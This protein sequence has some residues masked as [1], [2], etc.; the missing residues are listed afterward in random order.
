MSR[1][2]LPLDLSSF[3]GRA[4]E[5]DQLAELVT[6]SRLITLT[7]GPGA[8]KTRLAL[9]LVRG[10]LPP[11]RRVAWTEL[12]PLGEP[13][14]VAP[15]IADALQ[16][17]EEV[18]AGDVEALA[19]LIGDGDLLLVLDNCEHLVDAVA[20]VA[21]VLLR[22]YTDLCIVATSREA[23][24]V[25]GERAW[26]VPPLALPGP[27]DAESLG[28]SEAVRLFLERARD[29][30]PGFELSEESAPAVAEICRRL[31]GIPLAIELAAARMRLMSPAEVLG[32]LDDVFHLLTDDRRTTSPRH[33][34][35]R[36]AIDWSHDLLR[37][38]AR[39]LLRRLAVFQGG[40]TLEAA[41]QVGPGDGIAPEEVLDGVG[42]LVD[43]SMLVVREGHGFTRYHLLEAVRQYA[44]EKL[45]ASGGDRDVRSVH[46]GYFLQLTEK[47]EPH[48][49]DRDRRVWVDRLQS[50]IDNLRAAL[51]WSR[52]EDPGLHVRLVGRLWWFW[53]STQHWTEGA[54]WID[55]ALALTPET[56]T[57]ADRA[58]LLFAAGALAALQVRTDAARAALEEAASIAARLGDA[59]LEAYAL[60]YLGMT[61][62]GEGDGEGMELCRRADAWFRAH[63]DLY[64]LR[65]ALLLQGSAALGRGALA[66]AERLN[67]EG[68]EVARR[69]GQPRELAVS[70]QNLSVVLIVQGRLD[71]AEALVLEALRTSREDL[72]YYFIA[73]GIAYLAEIEGHRGRSLEAARLFG[74][75]EALRERVSARP[76]PLDRRRMEALV[77]RLREQAGPVAFEGAW[78]TGRA[79]PP[80][81][82]L[83]ELAERGPGVEIGAG[84]RGEGR[85]RPGAGPEKGAPGGPEALVVEALGPF[86]AWVD[87]APVDEDRWPY[88][89]PRE[90]LAFLLLHPAGRTRDQVGEALWPGSAPSKLKNS[91]HVTLHHLR[92]A[93][94]R[95]GWIGVEG[96]RYRL[97]PE[98]TWRL[99][100]AEFETEGR[101]ALGD[102]SAPALRSA[103]ALYRGEL[104]EG[105]PA[106][107]WLEEHRERLQRLYVTLSLELA[108][109]LEETDPDGASAIYR[110]LAGREA[111]DE[112]IHRRLMTSLARA[113]DRVGALRH[114]D[115]L[116]GLLEHS[117]DATPEPATRELYD[118]LRAGERVG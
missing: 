42:H 76:F 114:Y 103:I 110:A 73:T 16:L 78:E 58:S 27:G 61:H 117:L 45:V 113:G 26:L 18:R 101:R 79:L 95:P 46:A 15:A 98:V 93:L 5:L 48:L 111:L 64:G 86:R 13:G 32:R 105:E 49:T 1:S 35:L 75:A 57:E 44:L 17:S 39:A 74:A 50:E 84:A 85:E 59:R 96:D 55:G 41:E 116:V 25:R 38:P 6:R 52:S 107:R 115:R 71:E 69:F 97:L 51:D 60:N 91:F 92:K 90:L 94:G 23:L 37:E 83:E 12:A 108:G 68:V 89:K 30:A 56:G 100:A 53:F 24:G 87:G 118:R 72:S 14:L 102:G 99:D 70:L 63:D 77:A 21:D 80:E 82:L 10:R 33:R 106:G 112:E 67:R 81:R 11:D 66:E 8:G 7:G 47:A 104:M 9:E 20:G 36:A 62:A 28:A 88:A 29:V 54:R 43:R 4:T 31:D 109:L 2:R 40:F 65:L 34:T 22:T 19:R 3:V